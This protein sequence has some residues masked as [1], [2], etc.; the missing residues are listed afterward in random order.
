MSGLS[1]DCMA[2]KERQNTHAELKTGV[3]ECG[4]GDNS[5]RVDHVYFFGYTSVL[6]IPQAALIGQSY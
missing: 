4:K 6:F 1:T 3:D 2:A 5:E